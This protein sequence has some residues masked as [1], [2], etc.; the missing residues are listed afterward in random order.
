MHFGP[1]NILFTI[2][3]DLIDSLSLEES[4][5]AIAKIRK[6]IKETEPKIGRVFIHSK[7][8]ESTEK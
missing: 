3:L 8:L 2:E 6:D 1:N 4:Q 7:D 5:E